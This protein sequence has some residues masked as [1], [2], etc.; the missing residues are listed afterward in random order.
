MPK[1]KQ[2][3]ELYPNLDIQVDGGIVLENIKI[4]GEYGANYFVSGT[5][6]FGSK[7]PK[8]TIAGMRKVV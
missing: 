2:L 5:G 7:N 8:E 3:R 1:V 4:A 6:I